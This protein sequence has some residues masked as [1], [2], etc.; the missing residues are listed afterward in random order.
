MGYAFTAVAD[1][2]SA[3]FWNPAGIADFLHPMVYVS[4]RSG[5]ASHE[6]PVQELTEGDLVQTWEVDFSSGLKNID[7]FSVSA[8]AVLWK[9]KWN[10]ALSYYRYF[11]FNH[12]GEIVSRLETVGVVPE[13]EI[14]TLAFSGESGID[15][16]GFSLAVYL[17]EFISLGMTWQH[18]FNSGTIATRFQGQGGEVITE[19]R[20]KVT[21][22]NL[23]IG[24]LFEAA[25]RIHLG[26][27]YITRLNDSLT[28][29]VHYENPGESVIEDREERFDLY[30]PPRF[31]LAIAVQPHKYWRISYDFSKAFWSRATVSIP[32]EPGSDLP[33]PLRSG[34]GQGQMDMVNHRLGLEINFS[35][36]KL[37]FFVR[38]GVFWEKQLFGDVQGETIWLKG[39]SA[40]LGI[41][42]FSR[43]VVDLAYMNQWANWEE[44]GYFQPD[45]PVET[46]YRN[47][48]FVLS[49]GY[50]FGKRS[51]SVKQGENQLK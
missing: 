36:E 1:D 45:S 38:G 27:C 50:S 22:Q 32:G 5:N 24:C 8:P 29:S 16:L 12:R 14:K 15:V 51:T 2:L 19:L 28:S 7:F 11:P 33:F 25:K 48:V 39:F 26:I 4:F 35:W 43:L 3:V 10:F 31:S 18:F 13:T 20:E 6:F 9:V 21:G 30:I 46:R 23:I 17:S 47:H 44:A 49:L 42:L 37:V 40:G 41:H 34:D